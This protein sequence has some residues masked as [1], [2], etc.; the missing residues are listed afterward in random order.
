MQPGEWQCAAPLSFCLARSPNRPRAQSKF[1]P[2]HPKVH[3]W[4]LM[5]AP[6]QSI[7][8][9]AGGSDLPNVGRFG[10]FVLRFSSLSAATY[11]RCASPHS[12]VAFS[13]RRPARRSPLNSRSI[14]WATGPPISSR[15]PLKTVSDKNCTPFLSL[16]NRKTQNFCA[17]RFRHR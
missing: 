15:F 3:D 5:M 17:L 9:S 13:R 8:L 7:R 12:F 6:H 4:A 11:R 2:I 10:G 1:A 16:K 14:D